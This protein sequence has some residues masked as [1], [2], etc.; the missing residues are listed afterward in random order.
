V[1]QDESMELGKQQIYAHV[2][3]LLANRRIDLRMIA[4]EWEQDPI[5][6]VWYLRMTRSRKM[7]SIA[8]REDEVEQWP[9]TPGVAEECENRILTVIDTLKET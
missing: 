8:F 6:E 3:E 4:F 9:T 2:K 7:R 1:T 5:H